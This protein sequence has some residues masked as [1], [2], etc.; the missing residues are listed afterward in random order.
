MQMSSRKKLPMPD[1]VFNTGPII[2]LTAAVR[3]LEFL[4]ELYSEILIP[5]EVIQ[6]LQAG[7]KTAPR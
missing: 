5:F 7:V 4:K 1:L 2:A 3:S 6:E